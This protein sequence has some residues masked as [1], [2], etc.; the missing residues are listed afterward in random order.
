M[1]ERISWRNHDHPT[2]LAVTSLS[3]D[4]AVLEL[5]WT[6]AHG[7][8]VVVAKSP[9]AVQTDKIGGSLQSGSIVKKMD[10][11]LF[12]WGNDDG[13]GPAK[14]RLLLEAAKFADSTGFAAL[15]TPERHFHAWRGPFPDP[16]ATG[17]AV[18][19]VT[20]NL[21]IRAGSCVLP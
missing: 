15:W 12:F 11:G 2:W 14:Y 6:L 19:A 5:F 20:G 18:A 8:K 4:I 1:D 7:F 10:F 3:F 16:A 9:V 21:S 13:A 17:A